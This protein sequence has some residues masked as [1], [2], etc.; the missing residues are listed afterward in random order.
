ML[1]RRGEVVPDG[2]AD[3]ARELRAAARRPHHALAH[4]RGSSLHRNSIF[5]MAVTVF[6]SAFGFLYW[7]VAARVYGASEVGLAAALI[8][9]LTL[10]SMLT[11]LGINTALVQI[12]P[13]RQSGGEWSGALNAGLIVGVASSGLGG[14]VAVFLLPVI[15]HQFGVL[16]S[17]LLYAASFVVGVVATTLTNLLDYACIAE[18]S[19]GR[20]LMRNVVFSIVKIPLIALP[21][22]AALGAFGI[23]VSWIA[24][25]VAIVA[26]VFM[27]VPTLGRGYSLRSRHLRSEINRLRSYL[28]GHH[29]INVG[30]FAP[31]WLL[32]VFVTVQI[33]ATA[34][35]YFYATWRVAGL[36]YMI[37]PAVSQSLSAEGAADPA[38]LW[39][40]AGSSAK[41]T[42]TLLVPTC[43]LTVAA[44]PLILS[45][46]GPRYETAG[47]P[48]L[49]VFALAAIPD[50]TMNI[51]VGILRVEG[52]LRLAGWLQMATAAL[53]LAGAW[54]LLPIVGI[55]G[56]GIGWLVS[57][58]V[59]CTIILLDRRRGQRVAALREASA[60]P[61]S[62]I[63]TTAPRDK[64][65]R[66]AADP[67]TSA[68]TAS[69]RLGFLGPLALLASCGVALAALA[70]TGARLGEGWARVAF[71][72]ALVLIAAPIAVRLFGARASRAERAGLITVM[73]VALYLVKVV[74]DPTAFSFSDEFVHWRS[75]LDILSSGRPFAFNPLLPVA[76]QY[77]G[78]AGTTAG[79]TQL[80]GLSVTTAGLILIGVART[81]LMLVLFVLFE[82]LTGSSRAASVAAFVYAANP[83]FLYWD[84][85]FSYESLGLPLAL[86]AVFLVYK[87]STE[88]RGRAFTIAAGSSVAAV[89]VTH[90][91]SSYALAAIL[92]IWT[93]LARMRG[94]HGR[95]REPY[96]P[97]GLAIFAVAAAV[98]WAI[99][100]ARLTGRYLRAIFSQAGAGVATAAG[101]GG[102]TRKLF[103][104]GTM[105]PPR[106]EQLLS[107]AAVAILLL[108]L[109]MAFRTAA[110]RYRSVPLGL[111][112]LGLA[113]AYPI[114]LP[115]R[116]VSAAQETAN[117][118]SEYVFAGLGVVIGTT[119]VAFLARRGGRWLSL[120]AAG[121]ATVV[122]IGG[123]TVSW[124]YSEQ[125]PPNVESRGVPNTVDFEAARA[126]E[127]SLEAL[128]RGNRFAT[129]Q[130]DKLALDTYGRQRTL[131]TLRDGVSSWQILLPPDVSSAVV[132]AIHRGKVSYVLVQRLLSRGIPSGGVYF[133]KGEPGAADRT[134]AISAATLGK[135]DRAEGVNRIF[136]S[137]D[138]QIYDVR[139]IRS[140]P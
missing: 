75:T 89:A 19:A 103:A 25:S 128:G 131:T 24:S 65:D 58:M 135:F 123:V 109:M 107:L 78:L 1:D 22:V 111:I 125:L 69:S 93:V 8:S 120:T 81:T 79:L 83:N 35:A 38:T 36:L 67:R 91:L 92:L 21:V 122:F 39:K 2:I 53:A 136:D 57:R 88:P 13:R 34:N 105:V 66:P 54:C 72:G 64:L 30:S 16:L 134:R 60:A 76:S 10:A 37:A 119:L 99:F 130:I 90:H 121:L 110:R 127:W 96:A 46:F 140:G 108:A 87:R 7:L 106:W 70:A 33:S 45:A 113:A 71:W 15:S 12:L 112:A 97:V 5:M 31:W 137:G 117:R 32:P 44:G 47:F 77:P 80:T 133:D 102:G 74:Y 63:A 104:A 124:Q 27:M 139:R 82:R 49:V 95:T 14:V 114:S 41:F 9:A 28:A 86:L 84:A 11:N 129:D 43:F 18:R 85:Q 48:L 4:L 100:E 3:I 56:A 62:G 23:V 101:G 118:S 138:I 17:S 26:V 52:R 55:T 94:R 20:M 61:G 98:L 126:A 29:A 68:A 50:A 115:L 132:D 59:G 73:T 6:A 116:L 51:Y 42:A 40:K